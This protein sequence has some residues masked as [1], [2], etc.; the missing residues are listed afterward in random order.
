MKHIVTSGCSFSEKGDRTWPSHLS[1]TP[2]IT[3][4]T[5]G[6]SSAG[7]NWI[8]KTAIHQVH[9]LLSQGVSPDD[10]SVIIMWSGIDRKD[11]FISKAETN[12]FEKLIQ[13]GEPAVVN[14][15]SFID[16]LNDDIYASGHTDGYLVGSM[17]AYFDNVN[18]RKMKQGLIMPFFSNESLA[19]ESY[20]NFL[21]VQWLCES[22]KIKLL[23]MTFMDIM[24]YPDPSLNILTKDHYRN[25]APLNDMIDFKNWLFWK[26][27]GGMYEYTCDNNLPVEQDNVHP[28]KLA[29]EHFVNNFLMQALIERKIL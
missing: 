20:E 25:I 11:L 19:I 8:A 13:L 16:P 9:K 6:L 21:R 29:Y 3:V 23:N 5:L 7:N 10:I 22:K 15:V 27:T 17:S 14:P 4:Y 1:N 12:N 2:G 26:E 18:I 24:H 28:T